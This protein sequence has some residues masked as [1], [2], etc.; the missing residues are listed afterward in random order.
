VDKDNY[1]TKYRIFGTPLCHG[2]AVKYLPAVSQQANKKLFSFI[3]N[4]SA[5]GL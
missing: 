5:N 1:K 4:R 3:T 2:W